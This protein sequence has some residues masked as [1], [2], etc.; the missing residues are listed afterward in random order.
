MNSLAKYALENGGSVYPLIIPSELTGGT[1]LMNPSICVDGDKVLVNIRHVN[2]TFYHSEAKVF[3]HPWG[4]LT[5]L[6]PE[7]DMHL[8]TVNY[9]CELDNNFEI[10]RFNKIDMTKFDTYEPQW[11][12]VG[13]ED[14]RIFKW[15]NKLYISGVRR[16]TTTN[17]QGRMELSEIVVDEYSVKEISRFRIPPPNDSNSYCEKNWMPILDMPYH[18][19]KWSNPTE[20]VRAD[21]VNKTSKTEVLSNA[22]SLPRDLRG[23]SQIIKIG[24]YR[25]AITHEVA[26]F[27]SE[28]G[29]KDAIYKHRVIIWDDKWNIVKYTDDFSIMDAHVEFAIGMCEYKND[30]LIT[31]GFQDNAA[32]LLKIPTQAFKKFIGIDDENN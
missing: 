10:S 31:F 14:A 19:V 16:D 17:G 11:D 27:S 24:N 12:F 6:H 8:R 28:V 1:G 3:Q 20:V 29:R 4:P 13:L 5:Y 2:Y 25:V 21:P 26:L 23:G 15:E 7:D 30:I 9:Y 22:I 18:Y 32:Y